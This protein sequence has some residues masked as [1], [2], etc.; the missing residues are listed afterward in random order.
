MNL[1]PKL[2]I[3]LAT[4]A[5]IAGIAVKLLGMDLSA[6]GISQQFPIKPQSFLNFANS[7]LLLSIA[8]TLLRKNND[9]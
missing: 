6:M 3:L 5:I 4:L 7:A 8:V 1:G 9:D 2:L